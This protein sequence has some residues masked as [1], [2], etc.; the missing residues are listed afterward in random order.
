MESVTV[1]GWLDTERRNGIGLQDLVK[2]RTLVLAE[3]K[4]S[5]CS[6]VQFEIRLI[7]C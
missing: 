1:I 4:V 7:S 6:E 5:P 2:G 3:F